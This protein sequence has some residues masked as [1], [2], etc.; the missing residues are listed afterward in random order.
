M[1][2]IS[3]NAIATGSP[4]TRVSFRQWITHAAE[5][6]FIMRELVGSAGQEDSVFILQE[7]LTKNAGDTIRMKFSPTREQAGYASNDTITGTEGT[8]EMSYD[9]MYINSIG[10]A[11]GLTDQMAQQRL[12]TRLKALVAAKFPVLWKRYWERNIIH[13]MEGFTPANTNAG[14]IAAG[15]PWASTKSIYAMS[16]MNAVVAVDAN[17]TYYAG[18]N[19]T[20]EAVGADASLGMS[21]RWIEELELRAASQD[22]LDYPILPGPDGNYLLIISPAARQDLRINSS[23]GQWQDITRARLEGGEAITKNH[24]FNPFLGTWSKTTIIVSDFLTRAVSSSDPAATVAHTKCA[25]F[26]GAQA[27]CIAFGRGYNGS[28]H[29]DWKEQV[30]DY[31][32]WGCFTDSI[33]GFKRT[34]FENLSG[35]KET[36]GSLLLVHYA[37][38]A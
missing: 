25:L 1:P 21:T 8:V 7:E 5:R 24:M 18:D 32:K 30:A 4:L 2:P 28:D 36:Y 15:M 6:Q 37:K 19:T 26:L 17:H 9:D 12:V 34:T 29:I 13:Q 38:K 20:P 10:F 33:Y 22:Y 23:A 16:G 3:V 11:L 35:T 14:L 31:R 27:G